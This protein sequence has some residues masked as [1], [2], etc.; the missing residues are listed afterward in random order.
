MLKSGCLLTVISLFLCACVYTFFILC[1]FSSSVMS[2]CFALV[3]PLVF[4]LFCMLLPPLA[5]H[6]DWK[7]PK[8][9][10]NCK[11]QKQPAQQ[12]CK[13]SRNRINKKKLHFIFPSWSWRTHLVCTIFL[14]LAWNCYIS[15]LLLYWILNTP[16]NAP[17]LTTTSVHAV[18]LS[19]IFE[20]PFNKKEFHSSSILIS[21]WL[22]S[23]LRYFPS[24]THSFHMISLNQDVW[25]SEASSVFAWSFWFHH[26]KR[27]LFCC[28][29]IL[30]THPEFFLPQ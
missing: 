8:V 4:F 12:P 28:C 24:V 14:T 16:R 29:F 27:C 7:P 13:S 25:T 23:W 9:W 6:G 17:S 3:Y 2:L 26:H 22:E 19:L 5:W 21:W 11:S 15:A 10:R 30:F 20:W 18:I 1:L